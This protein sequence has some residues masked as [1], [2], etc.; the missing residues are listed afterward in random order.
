M[1][2]LVEK[3]TESWIVYGVCRVDLGPDAVVG[4]ALAA[5]VPR[6]PEPRRTRHLFIVIHYLL[7]G[8]YYL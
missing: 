8:M 6:P 3:K 2:G 4:A 1:D 7:S 5:R